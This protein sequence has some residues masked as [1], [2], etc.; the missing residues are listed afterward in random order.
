MSLGGGDIDEPLVVEAETAEDAFAVK[1]E[2][3]AEEPETEP[4]EEPAEEPEEAAEEVSAAEVE[5]EEPAEDEGDA[6]ISAQATSGTCGTNL[7]WTYSSGSLVITGTGAMKDYSGP[8][9]APWYD[10]SSSIVSVSIGDGVTSIGNYAFWT[11]SSLTSV[12]IP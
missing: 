11:C 12:T 9:Y 3:E 5:D 2:D 6:T 7:T 4:A 1:V 10:Y 8:S